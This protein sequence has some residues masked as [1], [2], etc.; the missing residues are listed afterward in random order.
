MSE[1]FQNKENNIKDKNSW[2]Y[3]LPFFP[4][5]LKRVKIIL[6]IHLAT[7]NK[8]I[9]LIQNQRLNSISIIKRAYKHFKLI[10]QLKKEYFI[11]K[12]ISDRKKAILI[13]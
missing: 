5:L 7:K 9:K 13:Q 6:L 12:I 11:R 8:L 2:I 1:C 4:E 10:N 3:S